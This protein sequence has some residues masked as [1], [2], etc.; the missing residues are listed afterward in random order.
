MAGRGAWRCESVLGGAERTWY[1]ACWPRRPAD[2][3]DQRPAEPAARRR[4]RRRGSDS[5]DS[6]R[7]PSRGRE[8]VHA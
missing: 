5:P 6:V 1:A 3:C 2:R 8:P 4:Y 7:A